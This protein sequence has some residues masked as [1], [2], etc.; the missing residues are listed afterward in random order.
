[1]TEDQ[2]FG[3]G[4]MSM[5]KAINEKCK[6]CIYDAANGGTWRQQVEA[7]TMPDCPLFPYRPISTSNSLQKTAK[8]PVPE[9]LRKYRE[10]LSQE[11]V[12]A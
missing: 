10:R 9:G 7:C 2:V 1:M 8:Q 4:K 12:K 5:R 11:R 3:E 6:D